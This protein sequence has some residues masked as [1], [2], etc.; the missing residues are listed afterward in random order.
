L[1]TPKLYNDWDEFFNEFINSHGV[2]ESC[3]TNSLSGV[4]GSPA[5][6]FFIQPDG[7]IEFVATYDKLNSSYF[8][9]FGAISPQRSI[10]N[11]VL[12]LYI[13]LFRISN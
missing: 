11:L 9:N 1:A 2:I 3:P 6:S 10:P 7:E 13:I 12:I 4:M 8:R 5:I